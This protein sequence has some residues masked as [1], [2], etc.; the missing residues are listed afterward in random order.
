MIGNK[1]KLKIEINKALQTVN[2]II[3][4]TSDVKQIL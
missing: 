1:N 3:K 4:P 2:N